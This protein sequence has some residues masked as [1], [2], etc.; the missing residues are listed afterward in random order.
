L[1]DL[2]NLNPPINTWTSLRIFGRI[3]SVEYFWIFGVGVYSEANETF[4]QEIDL[5][6]Y[7]RTLNS[8]LISTIVFATRI[9][10]DTGN[11]INVK[12]CVIANARGTQDIFVHDISPPSPKFGDQAFYHKT[13]G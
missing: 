12:I 10:I 7:I 13:T 1:D 4:R 2:I 11:R 6:F 9:E 8:D 5:A 3:S